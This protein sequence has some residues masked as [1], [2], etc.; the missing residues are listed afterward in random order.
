VAGINAARLCQG[1]EPYHFSRTNS[2]IGVMIDDL[3]TKG[4]TEPY[5]MFTSRAE[6][7]L[8]LRVDNADQ[9]LTA[10]GIHL[11]CVSRL[12]EEAFWKKSEVLDQCKSLLKAVT[13]TPN[14]ASEHK[15]ELAKDGRR[16]NGLELLSYKDVSLSRLKEIWPHLSRINE[17]SGNL[18]EI[19]AGYS[20]YLKRQQDDINA[21]HRD[22][23]L[24]ICKEFSYENISGLSN[25]LKAKLSFVRP[26]NLGQA[27][28]IEGITPA[29]LTLL[30]AHIK[31]R[32][33]GLNNAPV[34]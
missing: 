7:R 27:A 4:V 18:I 2:Y 15:I 24:V 12:R 9:R 22:E 28:R 30:L 13:L 33:R 25:E 3:V 26:D 11:G 21:I 6:Y 34:A 31:L 23:A 32:Q 17:A 20:V 5:R 19:E 29:A 1:L 8:S 16:R 10:I 14:E